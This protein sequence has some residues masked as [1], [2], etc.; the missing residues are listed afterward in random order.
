MFQEEVT[1]LT[2]PR[3]PRSQLAQEEESKDVGCLDLTSAVFFAEDGKGLTRDLC[4]ECWT[5]NNRVVSSVRS[6]RSE[7]NAAAEKRRLRDPNFL[8]TAGLRR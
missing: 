5:A 2:Y 4:G 6:F 3:M 7:T 8:E 1:L